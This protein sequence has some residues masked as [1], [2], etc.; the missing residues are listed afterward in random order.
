MDPTDPFPVHFYPAASTL[1]PFRSADSLP[2]TPH[3]ES[4]P[5][6]SSCTYWN[7]FMI[8]VLVI[9]YIRSIDNWLITVNYRNLPYRISGASPS[10][11]WA[12]AAVDGLAFTCT[13]LPESPARP[14][15]WTVPPPEGVWEGITVLLICETAGDHMFRYL[16]T[17]EHCYFET[18]IKICRLGFGRFSSSQFFFKFTTLIW[19]STTSQELLYASS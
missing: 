6:T 16:I 1:S 18:L 8:I 2:T 9:Q 19:V 7:R 3:T 14:G 13:W 12:P 4:R 17:L 10:I 15:R 5:R 11:P